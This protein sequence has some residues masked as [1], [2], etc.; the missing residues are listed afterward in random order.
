MIIGGLIIAAC[1]YAFADEVRESQQKKADAL[2]KRLK[3]PPFGQATENLTLKEQIKEILAPFVDDDDIRS[4]QLQQT[5]KAEEKEVEKNLQAS[6]AMIGLAAAGLIL[7]PLNLLALG[8][9]LWISLPI[10]KTTYQTLVKERKVDAFVVET[11]ALT[12]ILATGH[13]VLSAI[14]EAVYYASR[15]LLLKSE[16]RSARQLANLFEA[17]P[18]QVWLVR[19]ETEIEIPLDQLSKGDIVSIHAGETVPVDGHIVKGY[20][21]IGQQALTG[22]S[23]PA[24]KSIG[25][26]CFASTLVLEGNIQAKVE[27]TGSETMIAQVE[28]LLNQTASLK[29][30]MVN[31]GRKT[32]DE[33]APSLLTVSAASIPLRGIK[34][35]SALVNTSF[36]FILELTSP[37]VALN[38]LSIASQEGI[39]VKDGRSLE[40]LHKIDAVVFDKTGI[41]TLTQPHVGR[42]YAFTGISE[43]ELL[44]CAAAAEYRQTH[45]IALAIIQ[46]AK[47]RRL[48]LPLI[49][50]AKYEIGYGIKVT[51][52]GEKIHVGSARFMGMEGI[53]VSEAAGALA[54]EAHHQGYSL[55][56]VAVGQELRGVIELHPTIR[57]EAKAIVE[58]LKSL[59]KTCYILSGDHEQPTRH[60]AWQVGIEHYFAE[61][62]PEEKARFINLLQEQS[63]TVCFI[64]DGI[65][66]AAALK[67]ADVSISIRGASTIATDTAQIVLMGENLEQLPLLFTLGEQYNQYMKTNMRASVV[68]A[69]FAAGG[70]LFLHF[71]ITAAIIANLLGYSIGIGNAVHPMI[72]YRQA[73]QKKRHGNTEA[74]S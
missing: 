69:A 61:V 9:I 66:D 13:L 21:L 70:I 68:P 38:F 8:G 45:P 42:I 5:D 16:N 43:N 72:V 71:G 44:A 11:I 57:P 2:S 17:Q 54:E 51:L 73:R 18:K 29:I 67:K 37:M 65:N 6:T 23:Q 25:D 36:G 20:A 28:S 1:A 27:K 64:G 32:A 47:E 7:P 74:N 59:N 31:R 39:L 35:G 56:Y 49:D 58:E 55:I 50:E 10:Y 26:A 4:Q 63:N 40:L 34:T 3:A 33:A 22:E 62:L 14:G 24:E 30:E 48:D 15:K 19:G 12:G 52:K 53:A 46:E 41:L 60:L